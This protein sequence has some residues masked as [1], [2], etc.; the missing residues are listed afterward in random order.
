M[1]PLAPPTVLIGDGLDLTQLED[2]QLVVLAQECDYQPARDELIA[3]CLR[4]VRQLVS[5]WASCKGLQEADSRDA[6]QDAVL[7]I[8]EAIRRYRTVESVKPGGCHFRT[9]VHRVL[10]SRLVD[11]V[12]HL[13]LRNHFPL[14]QDGVA[15]LSQDPHRQQDE[16]VP[17][18]AGPDPN[19]VTRAEADEAQARLD[20]ELERLGAD[21]REL[22]D[23]LAAGTPL[24][25]VA[26][27]LGI[28]YDMSKRRRRNLLARLKG[29]LTGE[30][31]P[32]PSPHDHWA[33]QP[34]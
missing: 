27:T 30:P 6:E 19:P 33:S 12:R 32:P 4:L 26:A 2:E 34:A 24:R 29:A 18:P 28:S 11:F 23:L 31:P 13:R 21:D 20:L 10:T 7:W 14:S 22:W 8:L 16:E 15:F 1:R 3:R 25:Q 5:H 17:A 9:F